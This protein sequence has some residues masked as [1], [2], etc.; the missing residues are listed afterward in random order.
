VRAIVGVRLRPALAV[1]G[2]LAAS[3]GLSA[4]PEA[5]ASPVSPALAGLVTPASAVT[6][7]DADCRIV[8]QARANN[9]FFGIARTHRTGVADPCSSAQVS[10][11]AQRFESPYLNGATPP[12]VGPPTDPNHYGPVMGTD[13]QGGRITVTPIFWV[14]PGYSARQN[15]QSVI[16]GYLSNV[17]ADSGKP[18]NV[19]SVAT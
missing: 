10:P 2:V 14:P 1:L 18:T 19:F 17:A 3:V 11:Q 9:H 15:Y 7:A 5:A 13:P 6:P 16:N 8:G 4:V 12:L